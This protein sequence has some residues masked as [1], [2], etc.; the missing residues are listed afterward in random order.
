VSQLGTYDAVEMGVHGVKEAGGNGQILAYGSAVING[1]PYNLGEMNLDNFGYDV[2][3]GWGWNLYELPDHVITTYV[4]HQEPPYEWHPLWDILFDEEWT[5]TAIHD[6]LEVYPDA[7]SADGYISSAADLEYQRAH[8]DWYLHG[9][10]WNQYYNPTGDPED[11]NIEISPSQYGDGYFYT[12]TISGFRGMDNMEQHSF[13][14][15]PPLPFE[16]SSDLLFTPSNITLAPQ[17]VPNLS[18]FK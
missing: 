3:F 5:T 8:D 10:T 2:G 17:I 18:L 14:R 15:A 7:I 9:I 6:A 12:R 1:I 16:K 4:M 11:Y 13:T